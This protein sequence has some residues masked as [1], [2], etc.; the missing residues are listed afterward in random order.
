MQGKR[1]KFQI[2]GHNI[3][4][5]RSGWRGWWLGCYR[6]GQQCLWFA[7]LADARRF[8]EGVYALPR[9]SERAR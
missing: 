2:N 3:R 8:A 1:K 4:V 9:G 6:H 7:T 5:W